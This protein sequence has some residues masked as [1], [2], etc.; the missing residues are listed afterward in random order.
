MFNVKI[1]WLVDK[2]LPSMYK[3]ASKT[4]AKTR[5]AVLLVRNADGFPDD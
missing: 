4:F 2:I 5:R 1:I 3:A